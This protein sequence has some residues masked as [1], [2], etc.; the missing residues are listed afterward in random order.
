MTWPQKQCLLQVALEPDITCEFFNQLFI[1][2]FA[3][4]VW[5]FSFALVLRVDI[6]EQSQTWIGAVGISGL[7]SAT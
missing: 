1:L 2:D 4:S 7:K 6:G 5:V 3:R